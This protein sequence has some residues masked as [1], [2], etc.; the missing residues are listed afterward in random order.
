MKI[1]C[2]EWHPHPNGHGYCAAGKFGGR[3]SLGTCR[4]CLAGAI[5]DTPHEVTEP[6]PPPAP[7]WDALRIDL[8]AR[9]PEWLP[10]FDTARKAM[11]G[12]ITCT[13]TARRRRW[14]E[15][16]SALPQASEG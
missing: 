14:Q 3:P 6:P 2:K 13:D 7:S 4:A 15:R 11:D 8:A 9:W 16:I 5:T 1:D 10:E 12:C